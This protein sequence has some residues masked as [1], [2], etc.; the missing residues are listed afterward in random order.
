MIF[1]SLGLVV[2][3]GIVWKRSRIISL[4][5][6]C[7]DIILCVGCSDSYDLVNLQN[8]Y[9]YPDI[10]KEDVAILWDAWFRFF[11]SIGA[12]WSLFKAICAA[13]ALFFVYISARKLTKDVNIVLSFYSISLLMFQITQ[14]RNGLAFSIALYAIVNLIKSDKLSFVKYSIFMAIAILIHYSMVFYV[15][16]LFAKQKDCSQKKYFKKILVATIALTIVLATNILFYIGETLFADAQRVL[17]Y[18]DFSRP[19]AAIDSHSIKSLIILW[20]VQ[21]IIIKES[22]IVLNSSLKYTYSTQLIT[23]NNVFINKIL[24]TSIV[25]LPLYIISLSYFRL[26]RNLITLL[27]VQVASFPSNNTTLYVKERRVTEAFVLFTAIAIWLLAA[28]MEGERFKTLL[29]FS[30]GGF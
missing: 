19:F 10:Y 17:Q 12:S 18:L 24:L 5:I 1:V 25:L 7:F 26:F 27:F 2:G 20:A 9:L 28:Y 15:L 21:I 22:S 8:M 14:I 13:L 11:I 23:N 4:L 30:F 3:S 6:I 16:V 29:S